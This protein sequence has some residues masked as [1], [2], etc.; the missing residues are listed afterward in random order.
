M[1]IYDK[2]WDQIDRLEW[3]AVGEIFVCKSSHPKLYPES[4]LVAVQG[5]GTLA[6]DTILRGIFWAQ[7]DAIDFARMLDGGEP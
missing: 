1:K 3:P 6:G 4:W 5:D 7:A 2:Y